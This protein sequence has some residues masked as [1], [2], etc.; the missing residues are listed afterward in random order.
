[1]NSIR[2]GRKDERAQQTRSLEPGPKRQKGGGRKT[3]VDGQPERLKQT[4]GQKTKSLKGN[5]HMFGDRT[6]RNVGEISRELPHRRRWCSCSQEPKSQ[7]EEVRAPVVAMKWVT[8][9]EPGGAG[10]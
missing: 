3:E 6:A 9:M 8:T 5:Y 2:W 10:K 1:M 7:P 4:T